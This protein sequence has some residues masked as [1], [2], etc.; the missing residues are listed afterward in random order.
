[1]RLGVSEA[2]DRLNAIEQF[3]TGGVGER[4]KRKDLSDEEAKFQTN[5]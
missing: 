5:A 3:L 1:M 4:G 2:Y